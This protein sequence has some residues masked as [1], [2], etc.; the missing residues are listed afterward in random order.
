M[1]SSADNNRNSLKKLNRLFNS[2][3]SGF[4]FDPEN[5]A[6]CY[7][8][9]EQS[10]Q[11]I[12]AF[13]LK[14]LGGTYTAFLYKAGLTSYIKHRTELL[15]EA[16]AKYPHPANSGLDILRFV[17]T[18][19]ARP[20]LFYE[21]PA[22]AA[23]LLFPVYGENRFI[24]CEIALSQIKE[25]LEERV[26]DNFHNLSLFQYQSGGF[27][28]G[29]TLVFARDE[30]RALEQTILLVETFLPI[31]IDDPFREHLKKIMG[32]ELK[33]AANATGIKTAFDLAQ[34]AKDRHDDSLGK[35]PEDGSGKTPAP[36][37]LTD[38]LKNTPVMSTKF[39]TLYN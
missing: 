4:S 1:D 32:L 29:K 33:N 5:H 36:R 38:N 17:E 6:A 21:A 9:A 8:A 27:F 26:R 34:A 28:Q 19:H 15:K 23:M 2:E 16:Q 39:M 12:S 24:E 10:A 11:I 20:A 13:P 37:A 18:H 7:A 31:K 30:R 3:P 22:K 14:G 25:I 35:L